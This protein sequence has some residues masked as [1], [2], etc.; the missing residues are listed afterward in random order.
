MSKK[1]S[2]DEMDKAIEKELESYKDLATDDLKKAVKSA[3]KTV[4]QDIQEKAPVLTGR[5]R[6]SWKITKTEETSDKLVLTVHAGRYQLTHLLEHGHA[7]RG[8]GRVA[9]I[10]HIAPAE[11]EGEKQLEEDIER[12]LGHG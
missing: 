2:I 3:A 8:G 9:A 12:G 11:E 7:K 5:Y 4:K 10:P 1:V 6:D